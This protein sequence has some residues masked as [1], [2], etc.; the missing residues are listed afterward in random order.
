M[1]TTTVNPY[2][3]ISFYVFWERQNNVYCR[4]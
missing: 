1:D 2:F 3:D 4:I